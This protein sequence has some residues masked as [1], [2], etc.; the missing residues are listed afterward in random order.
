MPIVHLENVGVRRGATWLI[1]DINLTVES[2]ERWVVIGANGAGKTTLLNVLSTQIFPT[3]GTVDLLDERIG[4]VDIFEMRPRIGLTSASL[5]ESI[6]VNESVMDVVLTGAW[7]ITGRWKEDYTETDEM[8]AL[9]LLELT[10]TYH[11]MDRRFGTLSEGERKRV[12]LAR[13][14]MPNPELLLLDEPAAGMDISGRES[15]IRQLEVIAR[16]PLSPCT[17]M[18]THHLE[19]IPSLASHAMILKEGTVLSQGPIEE[20]LT[21]DGLSYAYEIPLA[22]ER[23]RGRWSARLR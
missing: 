15:M 18:V 19:E 6:P 22:V 20:V 23:N 8:R 9:S 3:T 2:E 13:S 10:G 16:D 5:I 21:D 1:H 17:I 11:L 4:S 7:A 14:L 12:Q